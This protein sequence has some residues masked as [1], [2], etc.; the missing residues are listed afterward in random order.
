MSAIAGAIGST[1]AVT[2]LPLWLVVGLLTCVA[3]LW[4]FGTFL[5]DRAKEDPLYVTLGL[6]SFVRHGLPGETGTAESLRDA[7]RWVVVFLLIETW[8]GSLSDCTGRR[9]NGSVVGW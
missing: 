9:V 4:A 2:L 8:A 7:N 3:P 6:C 5:Y 1:W